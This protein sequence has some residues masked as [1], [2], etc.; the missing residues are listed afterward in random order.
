MQNTRKSGHTAGTAVPAQGREHFEVL[1]AAIHAATLALSSI[2]H[3]FECG[4]VRA[5][6]LIRL[7]P[8]LK[9]LERARRGLA[10]VDARVA[11]AVV[12]GELSRLLGT[13]HPDDFL[14]TE[15]RLTRREA[16]TRTAAT[17]FLRANERLS[18]AAHAALRAGDMTLAGVAAMARELEEL[19]P[20]SARSRADV[21]EEVIARS[22]THGPHGA[23]K[24]CRRLVK[25]ENRRFPRD[26]NAAREKRRVNVGKQDKDGGAKVT[27]YLDA[28]TLALLESWLL[29]HG[30]KKGSHDD[31]RTPAQRN[32]DALD[33]ALRTA[34]EAHPRV[35]GKPMCTVVAALDIDDLGAATGTRPRGVREGSKGGKSGETH[36]T[37][38]EITAGSG[39]KLGLVDLLRLG[40]SNDMYAAVIDPDAPVNDVPLRLGRTRR[41]ATFEQR[42]ALQLIDRTCQHPGCGRMPDACDAHHLV[43]WLLGG[44]TDLDN[45]TLLCR[46]HHSDNDDTRADPRR[47][48]MTPRSE[49]AHGRTGWAHPADEHGVRKVRFNRNSAL[50]P[51]RRRN[52]GKRDAESVRNGSANGRTNGSASGGAAA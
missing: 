4:P 5:T 23:A 18:P 1:A 43:A 48:H 38:V 35:K 49:D 14:A 44:G 52:G 3:A 27:A 41:A 7:M 30:L 9:A 39:V 24:L 12:D 33:L 29:T 32:A 20:R 50:S 51:E 28:S 8:A 6:T 19:D 26:P 11:D 2:A 25:T 36:P 40:M 46:R 13:T 34:H 17:E 16:T 22:P 42:I 10:V 45:L 21:A 31:G 37:R 15:L 47:G